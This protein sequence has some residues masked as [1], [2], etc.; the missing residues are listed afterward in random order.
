ML[1][2]MTER[3]KTRHSAAAGKVAP[4]RSNILISDELDRVAS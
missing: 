2:K 4:L 1:V 3:A